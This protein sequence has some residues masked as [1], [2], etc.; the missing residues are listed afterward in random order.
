MKALDKV[1]LKYQG[2]TTP[3]VLILLPYKKHARL[4]MD[5]IVGIFGDWKGVNN[6][7]K[8]REE[9]SEEESM[10][11]MFRLGNKIWLYAE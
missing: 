2:F 9:F 1:D 10:G 6:K 3:R 8:F 11:D 5:E 7:K 4:I